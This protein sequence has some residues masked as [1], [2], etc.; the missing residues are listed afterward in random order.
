MSMKD[1]FTRDVANEGIEIPLYLPG[2]DKPSGEWIRIRGTDSDEFRVAE[3]QSKR[4]LRRIVEDSKETPEA[5]HQHEM[6]KLIA[7]L[8]IAWSFP[9]ECTR[10]N[11]IDFLLNAPQIQDAINQLAAKRSLFFKNGSAVSVNTPEP[12]SN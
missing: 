3:V 7:S 8:V 6:R 12:S 10:Q 2:T 4:A 5:I 11:V 9:E 1:F